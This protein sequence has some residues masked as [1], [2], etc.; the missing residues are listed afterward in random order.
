MKSRIP[1]LTN[2]SDEVRELI[3][4]RNDV[5]YDK[6]LVYDRLNLLLKDLD[7]VKE[8]DRRRQEEVLASSRGRN[9]P[10]CGRR[11]IPYNYEWACSVGCRLSE[12]D[13]RN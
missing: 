9:C 10:V 7:D 11:W 2:I 1:I 6:I 3:K 13:G 12:D 4:D 5:S 8:K